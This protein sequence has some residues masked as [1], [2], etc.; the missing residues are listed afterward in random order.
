[1]LIVSSIKLSMKR[2]C[3]IDQHFSRSQ[4]IISIERRRSAPFRFRCIYVHFMASNWIR[5]QN[6]QGLSSR[7]WIMLITWKLHQA[8]VQFLSCARTFS[9]A[10]TMKSFAVMWQA[11]LEIAHTRVLRLSLILLIAFQLIIEWLVSISILNWIS[12]LVYVHT[13]ICATFL[14]LAL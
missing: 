5:F 8:Q 12:R 11:A 3:E 1:M 13:Y 10:R 6:V 2:H 7:Q 14:S 4:F 9:L